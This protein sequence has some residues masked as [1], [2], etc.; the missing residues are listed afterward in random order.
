GGGGV[1]GAIVASAA[2]LIGGDLAVS[3]GRAL[4]P[5]FTED[6]HRRGLKTSDL[7]DFPSVVFAG[8][9]SRLADIRAADAAYPLRGVLAIRDAAG[10]GP[11][12]HRPAAGAGFAGP[13]VLTAVDI[14]VRATPRLRGPRPE[15]LGTIT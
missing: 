2:E 15:D 12:V 9:A 3:A 6:A 10:A 4:P 14:H 13:A 5:A 11:D 7:A 1:E 8:E